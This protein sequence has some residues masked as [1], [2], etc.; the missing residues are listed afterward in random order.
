MNPKG[1]ES[2]QSPVAPI[3]YE[4]RERKRVG[5]TVGLSRS[6][7]SDGLNTTSPKTKT[8]DATGGSTQA[9]GH[10]QH[11]YMFLRKLWQVEKR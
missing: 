2:D 11:L 10:V 3:R 9:P 5:Q 7:M 1:G 4:V 6:S 8:W